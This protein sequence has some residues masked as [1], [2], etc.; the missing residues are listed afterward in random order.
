MRHELDDSHPIVGCS[1]PDFEFEDGSRLGSN[2][3]NGCF[4]VVAFEDNP[5][6]AGFV[7]SGGP[8]VKYCSSPAKETF[9]L[10]ALLVRPDGIVA[11]VSEKKPEVGVL[12]EALSRWLSVSEETQ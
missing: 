11:W 10:R 5:G 12:K 4:V 9:G 1:A 6:L 3:E 7:Q 8:K 2:L